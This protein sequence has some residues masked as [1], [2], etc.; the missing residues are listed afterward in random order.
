MKAMVL[1]VGGVGTVIARELARAPAF[2]ELI[3]ADVDFARAQKVAQET[4]QDHVRALRV[5]AG[6]PGQVKAALSQVGMVVN[7]TIPRYN[8]VVME[9]CLQTGCHYLDMASD[10]PV[11]L[12]GRVT[13]WQQMEYDARFK[14]AG[15]T[16][17]LC[18]GVDPGTSNL[19]ARWAADRMDTV[20]AIMIRDGDRSTVEGYDFAIYFSPDTSL[21]ECQQPAYI[22]EDGKH[23]LGEPLKTGIETYAFPEPLGP[24]VVRSV[25]HEEVATLPLH[26]GKG[27]RYVDFKYALDEGY[28]QIL[29]VLS[30][31]GLNRREKVRV[32]DVEVSPRDVI[33][34]LLPQ[35]A[36]LGGKVKGY[37]CV[38]A[39]VRGTEHGQPVE[40]FVYNMASHEEA[41]R[42]HGV[43]GTVWQ[44]AL[45]AA[46]GA[47]LLAEGAVAARGVLAPERLDPEPFFQRLGEKGFHVDVQ[48]KVV[49]RLA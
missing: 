19:F 3:L 41:Y 18:L 7:A 31:L 4:G 21:E 44:T 14:D 24:M 28:V 16:A 5:D 6:D 47:E 40:Y 42:R 8:L 48:K 35:P 26:I 49:S 27:L 33:T 1:G 34:A 32:G 9:A 39:L 13:I 15:L 45:P 17:I 10:G 20:D 25:A 11:E 38:G 2:Q 36:E 43:N 12:P 23:V 46:V 30:L 37:L 29:N 22:Y